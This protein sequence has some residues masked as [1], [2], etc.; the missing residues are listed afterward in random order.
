[1]TKALTEIFVVNIIFGPAGVFLWLALD[2]ALALGVGLGVAMIMRRGGGADQSLQR[3]LA[4]AIAL[5]GIPL[6]VLSAVPTPAEAEP[7]RID[8]YD[9]QSDRVGYVIVDE[10]TGRLDLYDRLSNRT[11][12]G[13]IA[14]GGRVDLYGLD[15]RRDLHSILRRSEGTNAGRPTPAARSR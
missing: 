9:R 4:G 6:G 12:Y 3:T 1:M 7:R 2:A 14:P 8:L 13:Q 5:L 15:G 11:G 10:R